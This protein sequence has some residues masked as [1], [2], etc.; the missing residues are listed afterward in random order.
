[1]KTNKTAVKTAVLRTPELPYH[2]ARA[3][4]ILSQKDYNL[5]FENE[6]GKQ[7]LPVETMGSLNIYAG[8]GFSSSFFHFAAKERLYI[9]FFDRYG[10]LVGTF[11]PV[12]SGYQTR[13]M[14]W[15]AEI[16]LD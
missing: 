1:M 8:T 6:D 2:S 13:T 4:G 15:Q 3:C 5:L 7:Y 14:L 10:Q 11:S 16:Y 9:H 12:G